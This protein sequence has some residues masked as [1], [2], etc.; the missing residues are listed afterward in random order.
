[1]ARRR[2]SLGRLVVKSSVRAV[3]RRYVNDGIDLI[4]N[5]FL[6]KETNVETPSRQKRSRAKKKATS[7]E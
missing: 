5:A 2:Q 3:I 6:P 1:M 4:L 7:A